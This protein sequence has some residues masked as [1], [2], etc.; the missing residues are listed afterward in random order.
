MM[1]RKDKYTKRNNRKDKLDPTIE[2]ANQKIDQSL[3][4]YDELKITGLAKLNTVLNESRQP[5]PE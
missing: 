4:S 1:A 2:D 3:D 5:Y